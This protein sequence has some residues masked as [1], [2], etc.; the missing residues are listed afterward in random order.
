[1]QSRKGRTDRPD[2]FRTIIGLSW[3]KAE[4]AGPFEARR[5]PRGVRGLGVRYER[6]VA[7]ALGPGARAGQW[8]Q[9]EDANGPGWCQTDLLVVGKR[10]AL[11]LEAKLTWLSGAHR[12]IEQLY[13]P[14]VEKV[15]GLVVLPVVVCK[16]LVPGMPG[17]YQVVAGLAAALEV[18]R[19]GGRAVLHWRGGAGATL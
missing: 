3:A 18:A 5:T 4:V 17:D 6:E 2:S 13:R 8:F 15:Y 19:A 14:I 10:N 1:M 9:F 7:K 16:N 12:Q 11:V